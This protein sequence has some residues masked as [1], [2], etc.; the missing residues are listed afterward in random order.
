MVTLPQIAQNTYRKAGIVVTH[1]P[2]LRFFTLRGQPLGRSLQQ[3][4]QGG[5]SA[6]KN[7]KIERSSSKVFPSL[8][9]SVPLCN[10]DEICITSADIHC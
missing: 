7:P 8:H 5:T 10:F 3:I 1:R 9:R 6:L 2:T 4:W